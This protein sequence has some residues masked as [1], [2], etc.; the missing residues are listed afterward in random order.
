MLYI[1]L[2]ASLA[3]LFFSF[4]RGLFSFSLSRAL[5]P[6]LFL[7]SL[8]LSQ[9]IHP[10]A[11][12]SGNKVF[13]Q[14]VSEKPIGWSD[15]GSNGPMTLIGQLEMSDLTIE[16]K[17]NIPKGVAANQTACVGNRADQMWKSGV[18]VCVSP[19]G[20]WVLSYGGPALGGLYEAA[21]VV[22]KGITK[23][24]IRGVWQT[25]SLTTEADKA[26]ASINGTALFTDTEIRH[27]DVGFSVLGMGDWNHIEF[28]DVKMTKAGEQRGLWAAPAGK[29]HAAG[30][31]VTVAKCTANGVADP[32]QE[33][34]LAA[35]WG[36]Q[37]VASG[38]CVEA[39]SA[40]AG[41]TLS[42][43]ACDHGKLEQEFR[44]DYTRIR[45]TLAPVTLG[46]YERL[47]KGMA[48]TGNLDGTA[49]VQAQWSPDDEAPTPGQ[50]K[51]WVF[52]PNSGALRNQ[53]TPLPALGYPMCL[54]A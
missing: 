37:H 51:S 43:Q 31:A 2:S 6:S 28:D 36:I 9:E 8:V 18:V 17:F 3:L 32:N 12:Y 21:N 52:F 25:L 5:P 44:N 50:W 4:S 20:G 1:T 40:A 10:S 19:E 45:N 34:F 42:L 16:A 47:V 49:S 23:P 26:S 27:V 38:M 53:Y 33:F 41:A 13:K 14:M 24:F 54:T 7:F 11:D 48:L 22:A 30:D 15:H 29:G 35:D 46:A 39:S